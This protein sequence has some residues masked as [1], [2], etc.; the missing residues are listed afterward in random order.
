MSVTSRSPIRLL[1]VDDDEDL[2]A[3]LASRFE[4]LGTAVTAVASGEEGLARAAR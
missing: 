2:R 3:T 4:R 1:I